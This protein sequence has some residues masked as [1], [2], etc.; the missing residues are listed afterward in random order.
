MGSSCGKGHGAKVYR[1][2]EICKRTENHCFPHIGARC[3]VAQPSLTHKMPCMNQRD[4]LP[5]PTWP[6]LGALIQA[7][8]AQLHGSPALVYP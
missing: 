6:Q 4:L 3:P 2:A 1:V 8:P 7:Q 5:G